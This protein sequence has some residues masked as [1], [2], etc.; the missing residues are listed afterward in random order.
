[1]KK[2][3]RNASDKVFLGVLS[4]MGDYF[5]TDPVLM[6]VIYIVITFLTGI[7]PG[8]IAYFLAALVMPQKASA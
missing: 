2:L 8:T 7:F 3:T 1:M 4:G 6:R 5:G